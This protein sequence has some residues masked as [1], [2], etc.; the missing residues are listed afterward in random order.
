IQKIRNG[1]IEINRITKTVLVIDEA[2][3]IN[4]EEYELITTLM[5][6]NEEMRVILVGDDDQNIYGFRGADSKYMQQLIAQKNAAM[7]ELTENYRSKANIVSFAN[8]WATNINRRLK[9]QPG[10][11]INSEAGNI[12]ITQYSTNNLIVPLANSVLNTDLKGSTCI[13]TKTN[14]EAMLLTGLLIKNGLPAKLIQS[15][16]GFNLTNLYEIRHFSKL[17]FQNEDSPIISQE[18]WNEAIR[19]LNTD[20]K[21]SNQLD[22]VLKIISEFDQVNQNRKY[23][24]DWSSF[25][26]E[27]K[28]EDFTNIDSETIYVSTIHKAKGKEFDNVY[29]MLNQLRPYEDEAKRQLYVAITRAKSNLHI[30]YNES[31]LRGYLQESVSYKFDNNT[32]SEPEHLSIWLTHR[33]IYL[34]Y[35]EFVQQR[36][37]GLH[38][39]KNLTILKEGLGNT[40]DQ[41]LIRYS[42]SFTNQLEE[43]IN[44]GYKLSNARI[45]FIVYWNNKDK[46]L[47]SKIILPEIT[48][49]KV[50]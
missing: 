37:N 9:S 12:S 15:N 43:Y 27:S 30:H 7:Y 35:F 48:L 8:Q 23:K 26:T 16:D 20:C 3:D 36:M 21:G 14:D 45:N 22:L 13:L 2:Q 49:T 28:I 17:I 39:G 42:R 25:L 33:D 38:S 47:E 6:L 32:F 4:D 24:S 18:T 44:K 29:V 41:L 50:Q 31:F 40:N 34:S 11:A 1:E 10:F 46:G 5:D 19:Q